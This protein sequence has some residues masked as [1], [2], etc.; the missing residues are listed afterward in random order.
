MDRKL[1]RMLKT[2][3]EKA[4]FVYDA[5]TN[6]E[7]GK[8][9][10]AP[11]GHLSSEPGNVLARLKS[12]SALR[13]VKAPKKCWATMNQTKQ[14]TIV[15]LAPSRVGYRYEG[16][17]RIGDKSIILAETDELKRI[18]FPPVDEPVHM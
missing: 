2:D 7:D 9:I 18:L 8:S 6:F 5:P 10:P 1:L 17:V 11:K 14:G 3:K 13:P 4:A 15:S 12:L 16:E